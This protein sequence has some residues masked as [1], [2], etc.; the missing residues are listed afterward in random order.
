MNNNYLATQ[1]LIGFGVA[2]LFGGIL[3]AAWLWRKKHPRAV[4]ETAELAQSITGQYL[5]Y[6]WVQN[7]RRIEPKLVAQS[8]GEVY[9]ASPPLPKPGAALFLYEGEKD[10]A[11][12]LPCRFLEENVV[13]GE[14]PEE[15]ADALSWD[16]EWGDA[17]AT[18]WDAWDAVKLL[19][20]YLIAGGMFLLNLV[21]IDKVY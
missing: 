3:L 11:N 20:P 4:T 21:I 13:E 8:I 6:V 5:A 1:L 17:L 12:L 19:A 15:L 9:T 18:P 2:I 10:K 7:R 16:K 14:T